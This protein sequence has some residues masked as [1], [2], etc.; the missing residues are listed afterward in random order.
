MADPIT[1][2][3]PYAKAAFQ[4]ALEANALADWSRMLGLA[5]AVSAA[6]AV[7]EALTDPARS[8]EQA[9]AMFQ[10]LCG[11]ELNG[12]VRNLISLLAENRRLTLLPQVHALFDELKANEQKSV[13][14]ELV[15]AF[16]VSETV[17]RKLAEALEKRLQ[18]DIRLTTKIDPGLIGG[19]VIRAGDKV[20][21]SSIR[22][23]LT[24]LA[25][26]MNT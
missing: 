18:R 6:P 1:L 7:Y 8:R 12:K 9:A 5:A 20:M 25:E 15:S 3:R 17:S 24:K 4:S 11:D 21:D 26:T 19:A 22:G 2:A 13:D 14:V 23:K 10:Q 16:P